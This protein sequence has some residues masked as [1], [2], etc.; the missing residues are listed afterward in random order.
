MNSNDFQ[1]YAEALYKWMVDDLVSA[2][3]EWVHT[4]TKFL[5]T[6]VTCDYAGM[7]RFINGMAKV[8]REVEKGEEQ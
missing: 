8:M 5:P 6:N 7:R 2:K 1:D 4:S 3:Q